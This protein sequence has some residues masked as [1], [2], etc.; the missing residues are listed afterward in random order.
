MSLKMDPKRAQQVGQLLL[1][2]FHGEG[3]L[4]EISM[5]EHLLP[6][7]VERGSREHL[8][9]ITLTVAIDYMRNADALWEASRRT[10]ADP[11]THYLYTPRQVARIDTGKLIA[12][13]K[14]YGLARKPRKDAAIWQTIC[15]SLTRH[16]DGD[17]Y[18]LL[19]R[20]DFNALLA[21]AAVRSLRYR[22]PYLRGPK[23]GPLW[24]RMLEDSWQGRHLDGLDE[25][26]IPVDI[27]IA[28]ATVMT[29]CVQGPFDG[30]FEEL[31]SAVTEVWFDAC[32]GSEYYPL[33]F[34]EPLWH[35]SRRGCRKTRWFAC[36]YQPQCPVAEYC[37]EKRLAKEGSWVSIA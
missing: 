9:F 19:E 26:P 16:F 35:L 22:F 24:L 6:P 25:L 12:D 32:K 5:P 23:I 37:T 1:D 10:Y 18:N 7:A 8:H 31:R 11:Q 29:G 36:E 4:G 3:I 33:Q 27:H 17:V 30:S 15:V 2:A 20:A 21:I 28:A 14:K 34:D 13:M